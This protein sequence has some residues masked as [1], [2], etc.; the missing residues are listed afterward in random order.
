MFQIYIIFNV[1][2]NDFLKI[3]ENEFLKDIVIISFRDL[4]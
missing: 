1:L 4:G 3:Q 2:N